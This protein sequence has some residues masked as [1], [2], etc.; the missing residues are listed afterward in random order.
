MQT[1]T[2]EEPVVRAFEPTAGFRTML[3]IGNA[4]V[5][6]LLRSSAG[7]G[8]HELALLCFEGR[9]TGKRYEVPVAYHEL[10]GRPLIFT[11]SA[12]K[13]NLRGGAD[14]ELVHEGRRVPMRAE[15][16]EDADEVARVYE[17]L[18]ERD[19]LAQAKPTK[20]GLEVTGDRIPTC[21]E[22]AGAVGGRRAVV[23]L[24]PR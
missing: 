15:L 17:A 16:A 7:K 5:R 1:E 19:G 2:R 21:A 13:A 6:P 4:I 8:I 22:I 14:V 18:L 11:A 20:I 3:R 10:D 9:R 23:V 24:R 12:W